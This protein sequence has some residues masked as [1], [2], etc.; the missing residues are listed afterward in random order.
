[1]LR[2]NSVTND[3]EGALGR[4]AELPPSSHSLYWSGVEEL[5]MR[6]L[7]DL[8]WLPRVQSSL[9]HV[10]KVSMLAIFMTVGPQAQMEPCVFDS[11]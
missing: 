10:Y 1:M 11:A 9:L 7:V 3:P 2:S 5:M 4:S 8:L 6:D